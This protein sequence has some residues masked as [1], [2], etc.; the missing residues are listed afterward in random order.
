MENNNAKPGVLILSTIFAITLMTAVGTSA[1]PPALAAVEKQFGIAPNVSGQLLAIFTSPG[2]FLTWLLGIVADRVGRKVVLLPSLLI[3]ALGGL[4]AWFAQSFNDIFWCRLVQGVGAA[5]LG[6]LN[7]TL[8][9]DYY[10]GSQRTA[11][12][13]YNNSV[14]S[15]GTA[16]F[17]LLS[18]QLAAMS[19]KLPFMLPLSAAVVA[20]LMLAVR[21]PK[22][23]TVVAAQRSS[24]GDYLR[25]AASSLK[26]RPVLLLFLVS[27]VTFALLFGPFLNYLQTKIK[28]VLGADSPGI[29][30]RI[31]LMISM[32]SVATAVGALF[33]GKLAQR[34]SQKNLLIT[35]CVLYAVG[36]A[37]FLLMPSYPLLFIP[38]IIFGIAQSLNQ[39]NVQALVASFAPEQHRAVFMSLNRTVSLLG[40][41]LGP[42]IFGM[43]YAN[44]GGL[45]AVFFG[46]AMCAAVLAVIVRI[47]D[48]EPHHH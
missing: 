33:L 10:R 17:P 29:T 35:S 14:L 21:E 42:V 40:Q 5:S 23:A 32:M 3:F 27:L 43:L 15:L 16:F 18:G 31:G 11:V 38:T 30:Q 45:A 47:S 25:S 37:L 48:V 1:M 46:G 26:V 22:V 39:P 41:T 34:F 7:V 24:L 6:A 36:T 44:I 2:F 28:E 20:L 13:G 12:M 8:I 19:W 9:G 4:M